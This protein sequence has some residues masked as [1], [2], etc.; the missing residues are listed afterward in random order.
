M[1]IKLKHNNT[2]STYFITFTCATWIPL[3]EITSSYDLVYNWFKV[4]KSEMDAAIVALAFFRPGGVF[5]TESFNDSVTNCET[6]TQKRTT[7]SIHTVQ[8]FFLPLLVSHSQNKK[9][10]L[11]WQAAVVSPTN[12]RSQHK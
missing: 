4:L 8:H 12:S 3:F 1:A 6:P 2:F 5:A 7:A 10:N 9:I 11:L